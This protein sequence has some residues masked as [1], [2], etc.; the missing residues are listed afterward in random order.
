V[1]AVPDCVTEKTL[2]AAVIVADRD[3]PAVLAAA[4]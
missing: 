3:V 1:Q 2:P 4:V